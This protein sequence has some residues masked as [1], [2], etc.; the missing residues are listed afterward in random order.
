MND[1]KNI[2]NDELEDEYER[3][4]FAK[5]AHEMVKFYNKVC[6]IK[7]KNNINKKRNLT[8]FHKLIALLILTIK[9]TL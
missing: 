4:F 7:I 6:M 9:M 3:N 5:E 8:K 2:L 1:D